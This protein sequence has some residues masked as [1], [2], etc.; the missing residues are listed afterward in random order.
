[1]QSVKLVV[2]GDGAVGKSCLL[3]SYTTNAFPGEYVPTVFD[4]YSANVVMNGKPIQ[5]GLWDTAGQEDYD[6]LR[7]LSYPATDV[8]LV[9]FS[10]TSRSSFEN[11]FAKWNPELDHH[12]EGVPKLLVGCKADCASHVSMEEA[13]RRAH[14][15]G[16]VGYYETSALTQQGLQ[17]CFRAAISASL[18]AAASVRVKRTKGI[19]WWKRLFTRSSPHTQPPPPV[20]PP[21]GKAPWIHP[22]SAQLGHDLA[23]HLDTGR[24]PKST[25]TDAT[26][27]VDGTMVPAVK[28]YKALLV[29]ASP[30]FEAALST[31]L[32][33]VQF[34][35]WDAPPAYDR[36]SIT[37]VPGCKQ[38]ITAR[39]AAGAA[40]WLLRGAIPGISEA[41]SRPPSPAPPAYGTCGP[42][43][44][45]LQEVETAAQALG[46]T[47]CE[48]YIANIRQGLHELN[49][50]F[51][52][53]MSDALGKRAREFL[54]ARNE[55]SDTSLQL[56]DGTL[57]PVHSVFIAM[58]CPAFQLPE[59]MRCSPLRLTRASY[60]TAIALLEFLYTDHVSFNG[61]SRLT[62]G[63]PVDELQLLEVA[64]R[65]KL[66]RLV[67]LC[68]LQASKKVGDAISRSIKHS[69]LDVVGMLNVASSCGAR[70]LEAFLLHFIA[71]NYGPM[72]QRPEW[73]KMTLQHQRYCE[74]HQWPPA[75][76]LAA[77]KQFS[78]T[79][80]SNSKRT[81]LVR[82][83]LA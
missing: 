39:G 66:L 79:A 40:A 61:V 5:L 6:R 76:Y 71:S 1:M 32:A 83:S 49:P 67:S 77:V 7:P 30:R 43:T 45:W 59:K 19:L 8:F 42:P 80:A 81:S 20:M 58:R 48:L 56:D 60:R 55:L 34:C 13:T 74:E 47:E 82:S 53:F 63:T 33:D 16:M 29:A 69:T 12:T 4:N 28:T 25:P 35:L 62:A 27:M 37:V 3:I 11:V 50:S 54:L 26:L 14:A 23:Q 46:L 38:A 72:R 18:T 65:L 52:T 44:S 78:R 2:V 15:A 31:G 10:V 51:E 22:V 75:S 68:E 57:I 17:E 21:A 73:S 64:S 9:C 70:Q 24:T 41:P 36:T